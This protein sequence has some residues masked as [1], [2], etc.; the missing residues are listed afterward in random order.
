MRI[1]LLLLLS[2][3]YV[4]AVPQKHPRPLVMWHGLGSFVQPSL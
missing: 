4:L 2:F 3:V 1:G